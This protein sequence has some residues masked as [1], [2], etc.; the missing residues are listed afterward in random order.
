MA[1][2]FMSSTAVNLSGRFI[3][4]PH[5]Q[6]FCT[7]NGFMTQWFVVQTDYWVL[8]IAVCT[9]FI[10]AD[11]KSQAS[12]AQK[13]PIVVFCIPIIASGTWASIGLGL[14]AYANIGA[15]KSYPT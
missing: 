11:W 7:F 9:L 13:H 15:C 8:A 10:V 5:L 12:W 1:I 3:G 6:G 2:N 14:H 4:D